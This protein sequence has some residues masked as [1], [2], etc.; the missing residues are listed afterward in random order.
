MRKQRLLPGVVM[1]E[2]RCPKMDLLGIRLIK[3]YRRIDDTQIFADSVSDQ[4]EAEIEITVVQQEMGR[5]TEECSVCQ[6]IRG[7]KEILRAFSEGDPAWRG[8]MAS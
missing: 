5:H 3:A 1:D 2:L 6:A 8:T 4:V 7:R